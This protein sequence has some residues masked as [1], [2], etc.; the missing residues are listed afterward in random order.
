MAG[1]PREAL[2]IFFE[3]TTPARRDPGSYQQA[4]FA[5]GA[6]GDPAAVERVEEALNGS[7]IARD[8]CVLTSI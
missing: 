3:A 4:L 7:G 2:S 5:A 8:E 1:M 6:L